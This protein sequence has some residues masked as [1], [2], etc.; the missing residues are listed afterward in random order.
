MHYNLACL[1]ALEGRRDEALA[2]LR[3]AIRLRPQLAEWAR[4]DDDFESLREE[5]AFRSLVR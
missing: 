5:S 3:K 4:K 1:E 2:A